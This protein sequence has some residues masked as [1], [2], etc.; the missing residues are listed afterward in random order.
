MM[1]LVLVERLFTIYFGLFVVIMGLIGSLMQVFIF[2]TTPDYR[3]TPC[4]FYFI[5]A[6]IHE[7]GQ[8]ITAYAPRVITAFLNV[9]IVRFSAVWCM[10][11]YFL[12][13]TFSAIPLTCASLATIDQYL[14]TSQHVW[15][16]RLSNLK[17][18]HRV[19]FAIVMIWWLH[20]TLWVYFQEMSPITGTCRYINN[21]A[22]LYAVLFVCILLCAM[23]ISIMMIFGTLAYRNIRRTTT[24]NRLR[25]DRQL[26]IMVFIQVLLTIIGLIPYGASCAY[27]LATINTP[28]TFDQIAKENLASTVTYLFGSITYGV[29][30]FYAVLLLMFYFLYLGTILSVSV[31]LATFS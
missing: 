8:S 7:C 20:G 23:N 14:I 25:A 24:L 12:L 11:R 26:T 1:S 30:I 15:C 6:A 3:R 19:S 13:A 16:R 28:K 31:L 10:V 21:A 18:A 9:D 22:F 5:I 4:T 17:N 29:S 2:T 27:A